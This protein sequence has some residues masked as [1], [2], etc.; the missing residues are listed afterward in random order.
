MDDNVCLVFDEASGSTHLLSAMAARILAWI[1]D[2]GRTRDALLG[3]LVQAF[4]DQ[5]VSSV[6]AHLDEVLLQF[7]GLQLLQP[8]ERAS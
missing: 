1:A 3:A 5:S 8:L 6:E 4:P 2:G 7:A